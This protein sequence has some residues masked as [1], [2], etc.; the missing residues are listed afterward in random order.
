MQKIPMNSTATGNKDL[1]Q[2]LCP[3]YNKSDGE[4]IL[5]NFHD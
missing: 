1:K 4:R 5:V 3:P 2:M